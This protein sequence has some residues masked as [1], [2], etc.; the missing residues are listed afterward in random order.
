[1]G[2]V[3]DRWT[4]PGPS[5]RR[6]KGPRHGQ[7]KRWLAQWIEEGARKSRSF[8]TKDAATIFLAQITADQAKG[9]HVLTTNTTLGEYGDQWVT[10]QI[11][12]R[13]STAEQMESRWRL[14]IKPL[15]GGVKLADLTRQRVQAAVVV[16]AKG[17]GDRKAL[18]PATV[19][20]TYG[21]LASILKSAVHDRLLRES[22]CREIKL[23]PL[24]RERVIPL[25]VQQVAAIA[26]NINPRY[27]AMVILAAATGMRS[28]ELRGL[29]VDR[30]TFVG[31]MVHV[32]I[33]RQFATTAPTWGPPKTENSDRKIRVGEGVAVELRRHMARFP[34]HESGLI[35]TGRE[36]GPLARTSARTAWD[37][38]VDRAGL[39]VKDRSG[40]HDLRHHHAS[41]LIAAGLSV[42]AVAD[43]LGHQDST[44]TLKTYAHLWED[45]EARSVSAVDSALAPL[46]VAVNESGEQPQSKQNLK[47]VR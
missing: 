27:Q 47:I 9:S 38:A 35:F 37:G 1:M 21:Y 2:H 26:A 24:S 23:P 6:I 31:G 40:W 25:T 20:V 33:D 32:R 19:E 17:E 11:H 45:D 18:A 16:W 41:L 46:L 22:P 42:T 39:V 43:R 10:S 13:P 8:D 4:I 28:G 3:Q 12:Q 29:T 5:G 30:L 44:E 34:P 7:G 14:H 15:L 36:G